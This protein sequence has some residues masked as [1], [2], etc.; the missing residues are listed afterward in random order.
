MST[1]ALGK[2]NAVKHVLDW[3]KSLG[4]VLQKLE[5]NMNGVAE[6]LKSAI[7]EETTVFQKSKVAM[8]LLKVGRLDAETCSLQLKLGQA[9]QRIMGMQTFVID[10]TSKNRISPHPRKWLQIRV[11]TVELLHSS[12]LFAQAKTLAEIGLE[13]AI[14]FKSRSYE[15]KLRGLLL[16]SQTVGSD[17]EHMNPLLLEFQ[18]RIVQERTLL[19]G[20]F[21]LSECWRYVGDIV[22]LIMPDRKEVIAMA[23]DQAEEF[24]TKF[25]EPAPLSGYRIPLTSHS[26][27]YAAK[28]SIMYQRALHYHSVSNFSESHK[29]IREVVLLA[30]QIRNAIPS[31]LCLRITLT[32]SDTMYRTLQSVQPGKSQA[33]RR[34]DIRRGFSDVLVAEIAAGGTDST[35]LRTAYEGLLAVAIEEGDEFASRRIGHC[36]SYVAQ[37]A[38]KSNGRKFGDIGG[39]DKQIASYADEKSGFMLGELYLREKGR[40][41]MLS[42]FSSTAELPDVEQC[43]K[44]YTLQSVLAARQDI[45]NSRNHLE[46]Y[47][48]DPFHQTLEFKLRRYNHYLNNLP[49]SSDF[50]KKL[51]LTNIMFGTLAV[52]SGID[53]SAAP[54]KSQLPFTQANP[55][56]QELVN[57][58]CMQWLNLP[59]RIIDGEG[60]AINDRL[61]DLVICFAL[62]ARPDSGS[63]KG[64]GKPGSGGSSS[65]AA[66]AALGSAG[67]RR[68]SI[69]IGPGSRRESAVQLAAP[70]PPS[71]R[72]ASAMILVSASST[73]GLA[74]ANLCPIFTTKVQESRISEVLGAVKRAVMALKKFNVTRDEKY[75]QQAQ[76]IFEIVLQSVVFAISKMHLDLSTIGAKPA[77]SEPVLECIQRMFTVTEGYTS[78]MVEDVAIF[79]WIRRVVS[80]L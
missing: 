23:Y 43:S 70:R 68:T 80:S 46:I 39:I 27:Y 4:G 13:E 63:K 75:K 57:Q 14:E 10:F 16:M 44:A 32:F 11:A 22:N 12:G 34:E 41:L 78:Q 54:A 52:S 74:G 8:M 25:L 59:V 1:D 62:D 60:E 48:T 42:A 47:T 28:A 65:G 49:F 76:E 29:L 36:L 21:V 9:V 66:A 64:T 45:L 55:K 61:W 24:F 50:S 77:L 30:Q 67:R 31:H 56:A 20:D 5:E 71:S 33:Q 40:S 2:S 79:E 15:L 17:S 53:T 35:I 7:S 19:A 38:T 26:P 72:R 18:K 51:C 58:A 73:S 37:L 3:G 69:S 6:L